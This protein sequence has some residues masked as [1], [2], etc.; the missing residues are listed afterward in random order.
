MEQHVADMSGKT[1]VITGGNS[2][3][4]KETAIAL[5]RAG[6]HVAITAR[7]GGRGDAAVVDI[8]AKSGRS[9]VDLVLFA[10]ASLASVRTGAAEIVDRF[11]GVDVL[12]NNAG[13]VLSERRLSED[14]F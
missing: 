3:I 14:G 2:G 4:G 6:A 11:G 10:L 9:D 7:D 8:K 5:A 12:V 13:I 1:V